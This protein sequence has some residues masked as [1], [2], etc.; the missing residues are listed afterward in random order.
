[1]AKTLPLADD[2]DLHLDAF[3]NLS[4]TD[5]DVSLAQDVAS[6][7]RTFL[8]ECWYDTSLGLPYFEAILGQRPPRSLVVAKIQQEALR[9]PEV[10]TAVVRFLGLKDRALTGVLAITRTNT[11]TPLTVTF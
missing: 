6:A 5:P 11:S 8:G 9:V 1:M 3:G 4:L 2:W 7:I 10:G